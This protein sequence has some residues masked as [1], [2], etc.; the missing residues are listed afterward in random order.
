MDPGCLQPLFVP[1]DDLTLLASWVNDFP[2]G[3]HD[4]IRFYA[5]PETDLFEALKPWYAAGLDDPYVHVVTD[6]K[7]LHPP[8]GRDLN[9]RVYKDHK[10]YGP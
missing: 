7:T 6:W 8:F 1:G 4:R 3:D 9:D 2:L 5:H 10:E